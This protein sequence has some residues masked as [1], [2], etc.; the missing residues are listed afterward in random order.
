[1]GNRI[2]KIEIRRKDIVSDMGVYSSRQITNN[3][4]KEV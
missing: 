2:S 1:M 4:E 3:P